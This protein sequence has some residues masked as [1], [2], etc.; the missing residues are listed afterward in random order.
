MGQWNHSICR[1]RT[2]APISATSSILNSSSCGL[3]GQPADKMIR[4]SWVRSAWTSHDLTWT[5]KIY[6]H[7]LKQGQRWFQTNLRFTISNKNGKEHEIF[8]IN[9]CGWWESKQINSVHQPWLYQT[10]HSALYFTSSDRFSISTVSSKPCF[11]SQDYIN[12][13]PWN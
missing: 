3:A 10:I 6:P 5:P 11:I 7:L 8:S 1:F 12:Y 9:V 4:S 13:P 2:C